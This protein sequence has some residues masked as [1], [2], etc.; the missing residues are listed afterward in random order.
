M[1]HRSDDKQY[2]SKDIHIMYLR[3][4][5][6]RH[7][8]GHMAPNIHINNDSYLNRKITLYQSTL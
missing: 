1:L 6:H 5:A 8:T 3:F 2:V 7:L 4:T